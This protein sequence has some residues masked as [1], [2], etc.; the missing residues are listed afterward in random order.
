MISLT[1]ISFKDILFFWNGGD[2]NWYFLWYLVGTAVTGFFYWK[3]TY[4]DGFL[5]ICQCQKFG[6][7]ASSFLWI[8]IQFWPPPPLSFPAKMFAKVAF[9]VN[10]LSDGKRRLCR[11]FQYLHQKGRMKKGFESTIY[12]GPADILEL[13]VGGSQ[14]W[15]DISGWSFFWFK[16]CSVFLS[17][18]SV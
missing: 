4:M 8:Q 9:W 17:G 11:C 13:T 16:Y 15:S 12:F 6:K 1:C 14:I 3:L 2:P 7:F 18:R 5:T 10:L